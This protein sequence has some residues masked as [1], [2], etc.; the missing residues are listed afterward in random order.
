MA[1][2]TRTALVIAIVALLGAL[3]GDARGDAAD[4]KQAN[5][6]LSSQAKDKTRMD[7]LGAAKIE[8]S[9]IGTWL[10]EASNAVKEDDEEKCRKALDRIRA[11]LALVDQQVA[12]SQLEGR[13]KQL[14]AAVAEAR[15]AGAAAKR[16]LEDKQA[17]LRAIKITQPK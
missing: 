13:A 8:L 14:D 3:V 9:Q 2:C 1:L 7:T 12:L 11:Q 6:D 10:D 5:A 17:K 15:K 16:E 4:L